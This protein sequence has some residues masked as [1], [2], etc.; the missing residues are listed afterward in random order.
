[1][2]HGSGITIGHLYS[3]PLVD[4]NFQSSD[5]NHMVPVEC[6]DHQQEYELLSDIVDAC[7]DLSRVTLH[8]VP[9]TVESFQSCFRYCKILHFS[10]A[11]FFLGVNL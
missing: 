3:N 6:L 7:Q 9:A 4:I 11:L 1:M 5:G 2:F 8:S 10:G